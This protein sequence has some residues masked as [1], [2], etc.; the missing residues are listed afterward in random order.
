MKKLMALALTMVCALCL[1]SCSQQGQQDLANP[2]QP[3]KIDDNFFDHV[4]Y[5]AMINLEVMDGKFRFQRIATTPCI[6]YSSVPISDMPKE[7]MYKDRHDI[8]TTFFQAM[9]GKDAIMSTPECVFSHYI[10]L[11]DTEH[12]NI[13]WHYRFAVCNCGV[14][15]ITNNDEFICTIKLNEDERRS[16]FPADLLVDIE[17]FD[18]TD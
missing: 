12:E 11:F 14:V 16:I 15:M 7:M 8:L 1:I 4:P 18:T 2:T 5:D 10:Y 13:P 9:D 17:S 3:T 6:V